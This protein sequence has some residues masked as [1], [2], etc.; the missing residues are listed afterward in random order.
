MADRVIGVGLIG[1]GNIG[2]LHAASLAKLAAGGV[3]IRPVIAADPSKQ[4]REAVS[5]SWQF[6]RLVDD[7]HEV[8]TNHDVDAVFLCT[9]TFT[10]RDLILSIIEAGKHLYSEKPL[11]PTFDIVKEICTAVQ[12]S[13]VIA[14]VG[15]HWRYTAMNAKTKRVVE[16]GELGKPM[17]YLLRDDEC[18]P[19]TQ[20][21]T[22]S[23]DWRSQRKY[24]GGGPLIEHSIHSIDLASWMFGHPIRVSAATRSMLGFDV[25]DIAAVVIEHESGVIGTLMTVYGGVVNRH[26]TRVEVFCERGIVETTRGVLVDTKENSF[27]MQLAEQNAINID[28]GD[29]LD[30]YLKTF[31]ISE[32]PALWNELASRSFFR[33]IQSGKPASPGFEDALFAHAAVEAAYRS[34][35]AKTAVE[36]AE[37]LGD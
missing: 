21:N 25:E 31:G 37:V 32:R 5:Y 16:S 17:S 4:S 36:I 19:T 2:Q 33:S 27:R 8:L 11:A 6:E 12:Q 24:S 1:C 3:P 13:P 18:W 28:P 15:F 9:P 34:A 7:P 14:Q 10:H 22:F 35:R 20:H 26:E 23:S 30:Q 29:I